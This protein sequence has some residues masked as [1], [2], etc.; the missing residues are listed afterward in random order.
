MGFGGAKC[1]LFQQFEERLSFKGLACPLVLW[2]RGLGPAVPRSPGPCFPGP[3]VSWSCA[4]LVLWSLGPVLLWSR[5]F[6]T[7]CYG[8]FVLALW[9]VWPPGLRVC[10][11]PGQPIPIPLVF[12]FSSPA[13]FPSPDALVLWSSTRFVSQFLGLLVLSF[14]GPLVMMSRNCKLV[15]ISFV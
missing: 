15:S 9:F 14:P 2:S 11:S 7:F 10:W 12:W 13:V 3:V 5:G 1:F 4:L 8:F 6:P